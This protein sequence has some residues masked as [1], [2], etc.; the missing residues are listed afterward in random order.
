MNLHIRYNKK[1]HQEERKKCQVVG[2]HVIHR[3]GFHIQVYI[4]HHLLQK[5]LCQD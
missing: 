4:V 1:K 5:V 3:G 2:K